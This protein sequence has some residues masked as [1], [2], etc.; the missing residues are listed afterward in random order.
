MR[1]GR[2]LAD[3]ERR[4]PFDDPEGAEKSAP[5]SLV[6]G[7]AWKEDFLFCREAVVFVAKQA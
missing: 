7:Q 4:H 2:W 3:T 6:P 5:F 1:R